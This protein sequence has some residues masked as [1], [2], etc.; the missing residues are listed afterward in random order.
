MLPRWLVERAVS[1]AIREYDP[2]LALN[3]GRVQAAYTGETAAPAPTGPGPSFGGFGD[4]PE[5]DTLDAS[6]IVMSQDTVI[7][8]GVWGKLKSTDK[9]WECEHP[10]TGLKGRGRTKQQ[11]IDSMVGKVK[12]GQDATG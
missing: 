6:V 5:E 2:V 4:P 1:D 12:E 8:D 7:A 9:G 11:A 10:A 3:L